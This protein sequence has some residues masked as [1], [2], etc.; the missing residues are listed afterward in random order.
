MNDQHY[1]CILETNYYL[2]AFNVH[3]KLVLSTSKKIFSHWFSFVIVH[4]N[5]GKPTIFNFVIVVRFQ[6]QFCKLQVSVLPLDFLTHWILQMLSIRIN[7]QKNLAQTDPKISPCPTAGDFSEYCESTL[8]ATL[9]FPFTQNDKTHKFFRSNST[10]LQN[11]LKSRPIT[12]KLE[13]PD[14]KLNSQPEPLIQFR[15]VIHTQSRG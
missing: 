7:I 1:A 2:S 8:E 10:S 15:P 12:M 4:L 13:L 9:L 14:H 5:L 3:F 11:L 6:N